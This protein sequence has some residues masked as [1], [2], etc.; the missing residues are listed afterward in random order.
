MN[1]NPFSPRTQAELRR[2]KGSLSSKS[3]LVNSWVTLALAVWHLSLFGV[4]IPLHLA[5]E[6][7]HHL[8][9]S[10]FSGH[11]HLVGDH[12]HHDHGSH[13]H[14]HDHDHHHHSGHESDD[15]NQDSPSPDSNDVVLC[16]P[17]THCFLPSYFHEHPSLSEVLPRPASTN[18]LY[19]CLWQ[20]RSYVSL[21]TLEYQLTNTYFESP[22]QLS[23][24]V[25]PPTRA[26]PV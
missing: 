25:P 1:L 2:S 18:Q 19:L 7:H 8:D 21:S 23:L 5:S 20:V 6:P 4:L 15:Q 14:D 17:A 22:L 16:D 12:E 26:P 3:K 9:G 11:S 10:S 13:V 24:S